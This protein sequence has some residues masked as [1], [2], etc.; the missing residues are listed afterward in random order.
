MKTDQML[1]PDDSPEATL[2]AN[3]GETTIDPSVPVKFEED[4]D[5]GR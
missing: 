3:L 1:P 2:E 4:D 5:D